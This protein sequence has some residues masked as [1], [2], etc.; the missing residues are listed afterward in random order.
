MNNNIKTSLKLSLFL[1]I[2]GYFMFVA[3]SCTP[4][5][6]PEPEK[7]D[8]VDFGYAEDYVYHS[9]IKFVSPCP[10]PVEQTI[11]VNCFKGA[12]SSMCSVDSVVISD[13]SAGLTANFNTGSST[14]FKDGLKS[15]KINFTFTCAIAESFTHIYKLSFYKD[16]VLVTEEDFTVTVTVTE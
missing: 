3:P 8:P 10:Q 13:P 12:D 14:T 11:K 15:R 16:G 1:S 4:A 5:P 9:H 2:L 6:E 7:T